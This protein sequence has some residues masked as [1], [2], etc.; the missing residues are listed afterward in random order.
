MPEIER[1]L[2]GARPDWPDPPAALEAQILASLSLEVAERSP[3]AWLSRA[4]RSRRVR[5]IA[6]G[7]VLAGTGTALAVTI[8]GRSGSPAGAAASLSFVA[9]HEAGDAPGFLDSAPGIAVDPDGGA[10][11]TW[12]R[13][14]QAVVAS[15]SP[16]GAWSTW[17][18]VSRSG[19]ASRPV[20]AAGAGGTA[21]VWRQRVRGRR[22]TESFV[23][24][25]GQDGGVLRAHLDIRWQV[26]ASVRGRE[27]AWGA[28]VALS[29]PS[30]TQRDGYAPQIV[31]TG[32]GDV[33]AGYVAGGRAWTVRYTP[34]AGWQDPAALPG[35]AGAPSDL[36][37]SAAPTSGWV[38]A[39]WTSYRDDPVAGRRWQLWSATRPPDGSW[40]G[41]V[42][43]TAPSAG[44][45]LSASAIND[46]GE[47]VVA[48]DNDTKATT[49]G[50]DGRWSGAV[51]IAPSPGPQ[52]RLVFP[53]AGID[54]EGRV[55][56][57]TPGRE[58]SQLARREPG[59]D[60]QAPTI[61]RRGAFITAIAPDAAGGLLVDATGVRGGVVQLQVFDRNGQAG[62]VKMLPAAPSSSVAIG[63]DGTTALASAPTGSDHTTTIIVNVAPGKGHR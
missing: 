8:A 1:N 54:D 28:P 6:V 23:L 36:R 33:I 10:S 27:G 7:L 20:I 34:A 42:A 25:G 55:I 3:W 30:R 40:S 5:L 35:T 62:E 13:V 19:R 31:A 17:V 2:I 38:L 11:V 52:V 58:G 46:H 63:R 57:S 49:R 39:T 32:S 61:L 12:P 48:W 59:G 24:P 18:P 22:V 60:W 51:E 56:V 53:A 29:P 15:R 41:A 9:P 14:G 45:P 16:S 4:S 21:I 37:L 47:A 44:K 43:L 50:R 26:M